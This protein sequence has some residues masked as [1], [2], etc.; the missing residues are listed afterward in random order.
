MDAEK[1]RKINELA[2]NLKKLHLAATMEEALA[3]AEEML[4]G[5]PSKDKSI[6]EMM[7]DSS[8]I[9]KEEKRVQAAEDSIARLEKDLKKDEKAHGSR[10]DDL[11]E[12]GEETEKLREGA[13]NV[14]EILEEAERVQE[15][16]K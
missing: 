8:E 5:A 10:D 13:E 4:T 9:R 6:G 11:E 16:E 14:K 12:L 2:N 3:R 1:S 7:E 15:H